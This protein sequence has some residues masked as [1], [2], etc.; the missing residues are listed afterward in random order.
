MPAE[1]A[2]SLPARSAD[3]R[4]YTFTIRRGFRFSPPSNEP[5]TAQT[6]KAT[7][8]RTLNPRM[9]SPIARQ[10]NDI[11]GAGAY[12]AHTSPHISGVIARGDTLT[13][14]LRSPEPDFPARIAEPAMC[15]APPNTP[16]NPNLRVTIP[17]AGPYYVASFTPGQGVVL[18][19]NPNY[20]GNRPHHL[21]RIDVTMGTSNRQAVAD[22]E[23]GEG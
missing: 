11:V 23:A 14:R 15:A 22:V 3:G 4:T 12:M 19:R 16:P 17:S 5:V 8:E 21:A 13:V 20:R 6:F 10:F 7:I 9:R 1:V 18:L 2:R